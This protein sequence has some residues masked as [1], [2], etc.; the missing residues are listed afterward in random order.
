MLNFGASKPKVKGG[1]G[2]PA[3][4]DPRLIGLFSSEKLVLELRRT[5]ANYN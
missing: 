2:P 5:D 4:L 3:P 1:H